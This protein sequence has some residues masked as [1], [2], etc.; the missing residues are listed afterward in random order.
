MLVFEYIWILIAAPL[1]LIVRKF[2]P[3]QP[4]SDPALRAPFVQRIQA[5]SKGMTWHKPRTSHSFKWIV[6]CFVLL[7]LARPQW[8]EE[9]LQKQVPARDLLLMVDL[10]GSMDTEDFASAT[11]QKVNRL[12]AAQEVVGDFL[13]KRQGDRVGLVVFGDAAYLQ[14]P[15]STDLELSRILLDQTAVGM[16]GPR[17]AI[18]DAIGLGI[19]LFENSEVPEKTIILLTDGNDT[20]SEVSPVKAAQ[21]ARDNDIT[22]HTIALG[23]PTSVGEEQLDTETLEEIARLSSGLYFLALNRDELVEIYAEL[24]RVETQQINT[25]THR[26]RNELFYWPLAAALLISCL[27]SLPRHTDPSA[28]KATARLRVNARTAEIEVTQ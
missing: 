14:A 15:F 18:G 12:A 19:H 6:W 10:S 16:A 2:V 27:S 8:L 1:P 25:I 26:P 22:I 4:A 28:A 23:D 11:G 21:I 5:A 3:P 17:T 9:P 13:V 24:D 20:S 7:A